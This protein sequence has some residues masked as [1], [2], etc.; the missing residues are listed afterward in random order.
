MLNPKNSNKLQPFNEPEITSIESEQRKRIFHCSC[1]NNGIRDL[2]TVAFCISSYDIGGTLRNILSDMKKLKCREV[3]SDTLLLQLIQC[4]A[5]ELHC[6]HRTQRNV[7]WANLFKL[8][9]HIRIALEQFDQNICINEHHAAGRFQA[10]SRISPRDTSRPFQIPAK[11]L[12][13]SPGSE[14]WTFRGSCISTPFIECSNCITR[15]L[16]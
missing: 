6:R 13:E 8:P 15:F 9:K 10:L 5:I 14:R 2:K 1:G 11:D 7:S 4:P 16:V 12:R 3:L